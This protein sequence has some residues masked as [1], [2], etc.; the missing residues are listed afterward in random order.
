MVLNVSEIN[1]GSYVLEICL[2]NN[3]K[4]RKLVIIN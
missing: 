3:Q 4:T 1:K 2:E